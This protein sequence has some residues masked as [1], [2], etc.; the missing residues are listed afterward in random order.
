[1]NRYISSKVIQLRNDNTSKH[2]TSFVPKIE[3]DNTDLFIRTRAGDRLDL[4]AHE[5]YQDVT[6]WWIL[7]S[8]NNL[9][10]G[11]FAIPPGS[12]LRI[13]LNISDIREK[14][15]EFNQRRR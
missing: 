9:G 6:L 4:L 12:R 7:A 13:P 5:F 8:V 3:R 1:M 14:Y 10:K 11:T 15:V 2:S